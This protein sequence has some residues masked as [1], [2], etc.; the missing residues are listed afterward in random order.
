MSR[1]IEDV[2]AHWRAGF[3]TSETCTSYEIRGCKCAFSIGPYI[4]ITITIFP[5][6]ENVSLFSHLLAKSEKSILYSVVNIFFFK[7][8]N[9]LSNFPLL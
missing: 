6:Q 1:L 9:F 4:V 2:L 5:E 7:K 8:L 3:Q